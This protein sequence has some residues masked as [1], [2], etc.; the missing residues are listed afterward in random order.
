[1]VE[2]FDEILGKLGCDEVFQDCD[3]LLGNLNGLFRLG[4]FI[5]RR[6]RIFTL[7]RLRLFGLLN[8]LVV[9]YVSHGNNSSC[10]DL[11]SKSYSAQMK[12]RTI[13]L[14]LIDLEV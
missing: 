4:P 1:M 12:D 14:N 7:G 2:E 5:L 13:F 9:I 10:L 6:V 8:V 11:I 3:I